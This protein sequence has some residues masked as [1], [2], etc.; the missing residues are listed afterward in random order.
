[1]F[2]AT[3]LFCCVFLGKE[4]LISQFW[5]SKIGLVGRERV[6]GGRKGR[7]GGRGG[8][9]GREV[10]GEGGRWNEKEHIAEIWTSHLTNE[11]TFSWPTGLNYR[12]STSCAQAGFSIPTS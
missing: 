10:R 12:S 7:E 2:T 1:M 9:V 3:H 6:R 11:D 8:R 4:I 5:F